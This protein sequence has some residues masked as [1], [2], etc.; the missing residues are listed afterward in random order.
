MKSPA[1]R[2]REVGA[3]AAP[4]AALRAGFDHAPAPA[5]PAPALTRG[6]ATLRRL[7]ANGAATLEQLAAESGWPKSSLS[8]L[9]TSLTHA[10][11]VARDP[12]TRAFHARVR[13]VPVDDRA[14]RLIRQWRPGA[15]AA[16]E[17][18]GQTVELFAFDGTTLT[19]IDRAEPAD[20][21][22]SA[23]AR[24]GFVRHFAELDALTQ[25]VA[26]FAG[27]G[28]MAR[29]WPDRCWHW[30][31]GREQVLSVR[32]RDDVVA[33]VREAGHG[34][35]L[36][37]NENGICRYAAPVLDGDRLVAVVAIA[38][39]CIPGAE[40]GDPALIAGVRN[41]AAAL[42]ARPPIRPPDLPTAH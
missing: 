28:A 8:R 6:V 9:L 11:M 20:A 26:A 35:D 5:D 40:V 38:Q 7:A 13:L 30:D 15:V 25:A 31:R 2:A 33:T 14:D 22:V 17:A 24:I 1:K 3:A 23:K 16:A 29:L 41:L 21:I 42:Q 27:A 34:V 18:L 32:R 4:D 37:V 39:V 36:G 19:M 10:G 12:A